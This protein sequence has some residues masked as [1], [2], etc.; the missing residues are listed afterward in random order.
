VRILSRVALVLGLLGLAGLLLA[1]LV[2]ALYSV[3]RIFSVAD[4]PRRPVA[5][6]FG[7]G[8]RRDGSVTAILRDRV[9]TAANL[10][11]SGKVRALLMSGDNSRLDYNEPEAMRAFALSLGVPEEAIAS[12]FAG[13]R[14]YD[15]CYRAKQIF[16]VRSAILVTQDFHLP[17]ALYTCNG[18]GLGAVGVKADNYYYLK[19]SRLY[20]NLR[21]LF[22]TMGAFVDLYATRPTPVLGDP[23]PITAGID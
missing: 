21:E 17:R 1:R 20:W 14:T 8:L 3:T 4:A 12:D 7:A 2:T 6:V 10:Y 22:A 9:Q 16:G 5:I 19:R 23:E 11:L 15:T 13:R 18:L